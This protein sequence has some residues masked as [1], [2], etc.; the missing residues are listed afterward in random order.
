MTPEYNRKVRLENLETESSLRVIPVCEFDPPFPIFVESTLLLAFLRSVRHGALLLR[1]RGNCRTK[2]LGRRGSV[3]ISGS[4]T[5]SDAGVW[6]WSYKRRKAVRARRCEK[7]HARPDGEGNGRRV[8]GC[9]VRVGDGAEFGEGARGAVFKAYGSVLIGTESDRTRMVRDQAVLQGL[10]R[11]LQEMGGAPERSGEVD[12]AGFHRV[13][14]ARHYRDRQGP[15]FSDG[16]YLLGQ[17]RSGIA[18]GPVW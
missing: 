5:P 8:R 1:R 11:H 10:Y 12:H 14:L 18:Q 17:A 13:L 16:L 7:T 15:P 2:R 9:A 4:V 3:I 6:G